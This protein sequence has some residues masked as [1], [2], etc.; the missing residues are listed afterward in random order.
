MTRERRS[1]GRTRGKDM[2]IK[3]GATGAAVAMVDPQLHR[4]QH[5]DQ[6]EC[7]L[8]QTKITQHERLVQFLLCIQFLFTKYILFQT[9]IM[10]LLCLNFNLMQIDTLVYRDAIRIVSVT[11][12]L[13][14]TS[15]NG[16]NPIYQLRIL[17]IVRL[18]EQWRSAISIYFVIRSTAFQSDLN[19]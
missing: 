11:F 4:P 6:S 18:N 12:P 16:A 15:P 9:E 7:I 13:S 17:S 1:R 10:P 8:L 2:M 5:G 19:F 3:H 14:R